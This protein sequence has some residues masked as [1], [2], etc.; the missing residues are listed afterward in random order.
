M[1]G[2]ER[3]ECRPVTVTGIDGEQVTV[4]V[5]GGAPMTEEGRGFFEVIVQ[6]AQRKY[7]DEHPE[8]E[9]RG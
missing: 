8:E 1:S 6:A 2:P 4:P 7:R 3:D 9:S 5:L